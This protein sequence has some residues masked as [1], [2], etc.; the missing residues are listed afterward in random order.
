MINNLFLWSLL[1]VA[2]PD[3]AAFC[4]QQQHQPQSRLRT[5]PAV[6]PTALPAIR[7]RS[8]LTWFRRAFL[9]G[10]GLSTVP[11]LVGAQEEEGTAGKIVTFVVE[12]L[13]GVPGNQGIVKL[14]LQPSWAPRGVERF[15]V[16]LIVAV[17]ACVCAVLLEPFGH[18]AHSTVTFSPL[19]QKLTEIGFWNECRMF[20]VIPGFIVQFGINGDPSVQS[21]WRGQTL[22]DDSVKVT[23]A[24]GTVVFATAGPN[25]RTTQIFFNTRDQGNAFLDAQGFS[26]IGKVIQG[27]DIVD[28]MYAGYG[29][30]APAGKGPNQARIQLQGNSYLKEGF[31]QLSYFSKA[32]I[33]S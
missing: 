19:L 4:P 9:A 30:G 24:R 18:V 10:A 14:Q 8:A 26:P 32:S 11:E 29:E 1:L 27:M 15:E 3:A 7:R 6:S 2:V 33:D 17:C 23:N 28:R 16:R 31:P 21:E 5:T 25:S 20:R 13:D 12:N 22:K